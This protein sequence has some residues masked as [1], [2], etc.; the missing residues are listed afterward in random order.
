MPTEL[1]FRPFLLLTV[2]TATQS[3]LPTLCCATPRFI[4]SS[5]RYQLAL[6]AMHLHVPCCLHWDV[7]AWVQWVQYCSIGHLQT[8]RNPVNHVFQI[9]FW[10]VWTGNG[11][12]PAPIV[13]NGDWL[14]PYA[15]CI[16][17]CAFLIR[18]QRM[19]FQCV[20]FAFQACVSAFESYAF[21][22]DGFYKNF[23]QR[24]HYNSPLDAGRWKSWKTRGSLF[25]SYWPCLLVELGMLAIRHVVCKSRHVC[26]TWYPGSFEHLPWFNLYERLFLNATA[27]LLFSSSI[28]ACD[29]RMHANR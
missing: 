2:P 10:L 17:I 25:M 18:G 27:T 5:D 16:C 6:L 14:V 11:L 20:E 15:V 12:F 8:Y 13:S 22:G 9:F 21:K 4:N 29:V 26:A 1:L 23:L 3:D 19:A 28:D 24:G 7:L